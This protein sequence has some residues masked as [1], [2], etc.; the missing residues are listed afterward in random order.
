MFHVWFKG[1]PNITVL[2]NEISWRIPKVNNDTDL[3]WLALT[4]TISF[5]QSKARIC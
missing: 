2:N 1:L 3:L 4:F 5:N